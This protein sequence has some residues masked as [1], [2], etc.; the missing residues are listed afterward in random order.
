MPAVGWRA[1]FRAENGA[2]SPTL[3]VELTRYVN[4]DP[5]AVTCV[6]AEGRFPSWQQVLKAAQAE[7]LP[8]VVAEGVLDEVLWQATPQV[9]LELAKTTFLSCRAVEC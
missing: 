2:G 4:L 1:V 3:R 6:A 7:L 9:R 5:S 8:G